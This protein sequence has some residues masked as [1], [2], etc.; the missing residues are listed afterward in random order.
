MKA[1]TCQGMGT[2]GSIHLDVNLVPLG[3]GNNRI[4][5]SHGL[6]P[7]IDD[8]SRSGF[9]SSEG[10]ENVLSEKKGLFQSYKTL[11]AITRCAEYTSKKEIEG[12][13]I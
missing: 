8:Q 2:T 13:S 9:V 6:N 5:R 7:K 10:T 3:Q 11:V 1:A 12:I 4:L